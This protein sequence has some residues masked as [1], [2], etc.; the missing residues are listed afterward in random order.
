MGL[1]VL[2]GKYFCYP[3]AMEEKTKQNKTPSLAGILSHTIC[4]ENVAQVQLHFPK[5]GF[6]MELSAGE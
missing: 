1:S 3:F 5:S 2:C 6:S 4:E